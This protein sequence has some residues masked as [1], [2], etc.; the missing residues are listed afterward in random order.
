M[1]NDKYKKSPYMIIMLVLLLLSFSLNIILYGEKKQ[2]HD[3]YSK[4]LSDYKNIEEKVNELEN[5][6]ND[7]LKIMFK[8]YCSENLHKV[9]NDTELAYLAQRQWNY[10]LTVNGEEFNSKTMYTESKNIKILLSEIAPKENLLPDDILCTGKVTGGDPNDSMKEHISITA[11]ADFIIN[12]E[13]VKNGQMLSFDFS[14]VPK[15]TII[16]VNLSEML[17]YQLKLEEK[18]ELYDNILEIIVR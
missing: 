3:T 1:K 17:K 15:G 4:L 14:D 18:I 7:K 6:D 8:D 11:P 13:T 10:A 2:A 9:M 16:Y 5:I 12:E